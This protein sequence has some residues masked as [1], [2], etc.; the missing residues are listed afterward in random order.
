MSPIVCHGCL[1][2]NPAGSRFCTY[3]GTQLETGSAP[4][5]EPPEESSPQ[6]NGPL[7]DVELR[8]VRIELRQLGL[9]LDR[10]QD[11]LSRLELSRPGAA[12]ARPQPPSRPST[13]AA[14]RP[15]ASAAPSSDATGG[16]AR[17]GSP[18]L[19]GQRAAG[20]VDALP[21]GLGLPSMSFSVDWEKVLGKNWFAIIGAL[22]LTIGAGFFLKLAFDNDWIGPIGRISLGI[23]FG[24]ALLAAGEYSQRRVPLWAQPVTEGGIGILYLSIYAAFGL[25]ELILPLPASTSATPD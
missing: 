14:T 15:A 13:S 11:R 20:T 12:P 3:C 10:L 6:E 1:R 16:V 4:Q 2:E 7:L 18:S 17:P 25:Y 5:E 23:V 21:P 22:A 9:F 24:I 8:D 19:G